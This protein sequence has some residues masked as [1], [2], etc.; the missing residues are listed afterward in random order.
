MNLAQRLQ[1]CNPAFASEPFLHYTEDDEIRSITHGLFLE[2]VQRWAWALRDLGLGTADRVVMITPKSPDQTRL[3]WACWWIGA[4]PVPVSEEMAALEMGFVLRDCDPKLIIVND[5]LRDAVMEVAADGPVI[6]F[7]EL[8]AASTGGGIETPCTLRG[9]ELA[10]L[11][12]TSG[13]TGMPKGVMISHQNFLVNSSSAMNAFE[14]STDD[15]VTSLLPYWHC[16][17]LVVEVVLPPLIGVQVAIPRGKRDFSR[18]IGQYKP[19]IVLLV[20]R[21]AHALMSGIRKRVAEAPER[22]RT[23]FDKAMENAAQ[24]FTRGPEMQGSM[25][26]RISHRTFHDP[27]VFSKVRA[28]F[29]GRLRCFVCGGAPLD[30]EPQLFFKYLGIPIYEG[31]GLTEAT[32][33]VSAN[34]PEQHRLGSCGPLLDWLDP[35]NGGDYTFRDERGQTGKNLHGELLIRGKCVMQGYWRHTDAS[36]K[37]LA[38]GWLHT[39]DVGYV[40]ADGFLFLNGRQGNMIVL[41]GGEKL[42]P[43]HVEDAI[44]AEPV[45]TE[46]MVI[47]DDCKHVY[48]L[49]N[50]DPDFV[51]GASPEAV[52]ATIRERIL[53]RTEHLAPLHRPLNVLILPEF[54]VEDGTLTVTLKVRRHKVWELYSPRI[55]R[56]LRENGEE[57]P[58]VRR[59][60][61]PGSGRAMEGLMRNGRPSNG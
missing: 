17:A 2:H 19:T 20:P 51:G 60:G 61:I 37:T 58:R 45:I 7:D 42:H 23:L 40:D 8:R 10:A 25:L 29:G 33:V 32:P 35:E 11:V 30:V 13:S 12:Y 53:A 54:T 44:K 21:I 57:E 59:R 28:R 31:Y 4:V 36:A 38:G 50:I 14:V 41:Q 52:L 6:T 5:G 22:Q 1:E 24:I 48:V 49:V 26:R 39:G 18:N 15:L 55:L 56:F 34:R 3:F 46:A 16:F 27:L 9:R 43:E 47:G